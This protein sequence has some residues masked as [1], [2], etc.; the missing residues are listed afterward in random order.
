LFTRRRNLDDL[1]AWPIGLSTVEIAVRINHLPQDAPAGCR[2]CFG[3]VVLQ[4]ETKD[5]VGD[6]SGR[7]G[8]AFWADRDRFI[9]IDAADV[10]DLIER[11]KL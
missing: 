11:I 5:P 9:V 6:K 1:A 8:L 7:V 2:E 4:I 3:L 10:T